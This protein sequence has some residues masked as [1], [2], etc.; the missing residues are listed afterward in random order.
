MSK[1]NKKFCDDCGKPSTYHIQTWLD[2]IISRVLPKPFLPRKIDLFINTLIEKLFLFLKL[3]SL[4]DDFA[5]S[6]I[7]ARTACFIN[8]AK[9]S[10]IKFKG[11]YGPFGYTDRFQAEINKKIISFD[12]LPIADFV[13]K[14]GT[15]TIDDKEK[16]K[17]R[18]K[19]GGF[20][21]AEGRAFWFWQKN[22]SVNFGLNLGFPLVVKPRGGSVSRHVTTNINDSK[23]LISAINKAVSYSPCFIIEKFIPDSFVYR[24]TVID[25]DF[26]ACVKQIPANVVGDGESSIQK[27]IDEKNN[28]PRRQ[29]INSTDHVLHKIIIDKTTYELLTATERN[30]SSVPEVNE[31]IYLQKDSFLKLGGDLEEM[32]PRVHPDNLKLFKE[33]AKFFNVRVVG[34]DFLAQDISQS[35]K[36]QP[37]AILELN[38][39]PCIE[40]HHFPSSG[41]PQNVAKAIV[42]LFFKY[43]L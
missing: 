12:S 27:L 25:F 38:S 26:I 21:L 42:S 30:L 35:W 34:L 3:V 39:V 7:Q 41:A 37:C 11:F 28:S 40:L 29:K 32:T 22:K 23:K 1:F 33:V 14:Q 31:I 2:E 36:S 9:K 17:K 24:A 15:A 5:D 19:V 16:T 13:G 4:R 10:G 8:E 20:P 18:L 43:Y 6:D